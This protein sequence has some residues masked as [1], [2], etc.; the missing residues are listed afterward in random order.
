MLHNATHLHLHIQLAHQHTTHT[1]NTHLH[2]PDRRLGAARLHQRV[3]VRQHRL[4]KPLLLRRL[5]RRLGRRRRALSAARARAAQPPQAA[6][7]PRERARKLRLERA[8]A[9][10]AKV[11][12]LAREARA[13]EGPAPRAAA[14]HGV[15]LGTQRRRLGDKR[16]RL[17]ERQQDAL[18]L[19]VVLERRL[20]DRDALLG[21]R[22]VVDAVVLWGLLFVFCQCEHRRGG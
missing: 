22:R 9:E 13:P 10:A 20:Q 3:R 16:V 14:E 15:P 12:Q 17:E 18:A 1:H 11:A 4:R 21:G 6:G 19:G 2:D 8:R 5:G 7:E